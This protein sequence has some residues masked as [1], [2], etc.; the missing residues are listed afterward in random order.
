MVLFRYYDNALLGC[1]PACLNGCRQTRYTISYNHD[2]SAIN[3]IYIDL[4]C[5]SAT[6]S[7]GDLSD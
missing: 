2:F 3:A 6:H 7:I 1:Q 4:P 5:H